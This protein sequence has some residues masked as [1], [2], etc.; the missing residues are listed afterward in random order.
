MPSNRFI[1][2]VADS[3]FKLSEFLALE[4]IELDPDPAARAVPLLDRQP[5]AL[6]SDR[7]L[8][9][10]SVAA[11]NPYHL[12]AD[13]G[14]YKHPLVL[15]QDITVRTAI[16]KLRDRL[17]HATS[18]FQQLEVAASKNLPNGNPRDMAVELLHEI[19]S[20]F[21]VIEIAA[22]EDHGRQVKNC[23]QAG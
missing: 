5:L 20:F 14:F 6:N 18:F 16:A 4:H 19:A 2:S 23:L 21:A 8:E 11:G 7:T 13:G 17:A 22:V 3:N 12:A 10:L 9:Q 15:D 1:Q